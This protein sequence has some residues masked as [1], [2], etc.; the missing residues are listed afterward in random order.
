MKRRDPELWRPDS[1]SDQELAEALVRAAIA[2]PVSSHDR[3]NILWRVGRLVDGDP[4]EQFGMS[5]LRTYTVRQIL[6]MIADETGYDA[7]P[8]LPIR[9]VSI[10]PERLLRAFKEAGARLADAAKRGERVLLAT[11]HPSSLLLFY[12]AV[13]E[14]LRQYGAK[15]LTPMEGARCSDLLHFGEIRYV[16]D[17]GVFAQLGN[18]IHTHSPQPMRRMLEDAE[19]ELVFADHGFAGGAIQAGIETI[20]IADVN[21]PAPIVAKAQGRTKL[22]VVMDDGRRKKDYW[23]CY[24][25]IAASFGSS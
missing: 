15:I 21:D 12:G 7:D 3:A 13:A 2:G 1:F 17:V 4:E 10:E 20:A 6:A 14:L 25:A 9:G 19:P 22:V 5:G 16:G 18:P 11:G 23:P 24:Q 8:A